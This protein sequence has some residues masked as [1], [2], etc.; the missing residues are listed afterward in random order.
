MNPWPD[1]MIKAGALLRET[2]LQQDPATAQAMFG[3]FI[4][5]VI[6]QL[7]DDLWRQMMEEG[8]KPCGAPECDCEKL[9]IPLMKAL[10]DSREDYKEQTQF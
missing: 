9:R 2:L 8:A 6:G 4:T 7:P 5:S 10:D 3:G 1:E